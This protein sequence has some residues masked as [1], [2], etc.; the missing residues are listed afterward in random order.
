MFKFD[1]HENE[2]VIA[3]YRQSEAVLFRPV[4]VI[5]VLI[6]FPWYFFIKYDLVASFPRLMVFWT[7]LVFAYGTNR[8][9]LW[10]LN[11]YL[12]TDKRLVRVNYSGLLSKQVQESPLN[13]ILNVSFE[14]RGF[15]QSL[16]KFG[17]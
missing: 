11:V 12:L 3:V 13:Q 2:K 17:T 10:L 16:F 9:L 14:I 6:Y 8:Y 7:V 15:W 5:F 1:L 4:L